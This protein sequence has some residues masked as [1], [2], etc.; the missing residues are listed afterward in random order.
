[1]V[2]QS[3]V[4]TEKKFVFDT[5]IHKRNYNKEIKVNNKIFRITLVNNPITA[6]KAISLTCNILLQFPL[7]CIEP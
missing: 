6:C 7:F 5:T 2:C 3:I 4:E 1:M